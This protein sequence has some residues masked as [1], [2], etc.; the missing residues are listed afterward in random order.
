M[1]GL[2]ERSRIHGVRCRAS[3]ATAL[4]T[5]LALALSGCTAPKVEVQPDKVV[6]A[7][8]PEGADASVVFP[9]HHHITATVEA[10]E[11]TPEMTAA[12]PTPAGRISNVADFTISE[13]EF[14]DAGAQISF[15]RKTPPPSGVFSLIAHWNEEKKTWEPLKTE[16]SEDRLTLTATVQ[17]FS[18]YSIMDLGQ[19]LLDM[20]FYG[21]GLDSVDKVINGTAQWLGAQ[22]AHPTC[23]AVPK[24]AWAEVIGQSSITNVITSCAS[25]SSEYPERL[26]VKVTVNRSYAGYLTTRGAPIRSNQGG[27]GPGTGV[28][29]D[30][31][32]SDQEVVDNIG[33]KD[34]VDWKAIGAMMVSSG[35]MDLNDKAED[36]DLYPVM[37]FSTYEFEFTEQDV[38]A[39]WSGIEGDGK[40]LITFNTSWELALTGLLTGMVDA[41]VVIDDNKKDATKKKLTFLTLFLQLN[42]C[43]KTT[44]VTLT[45]GR[46]IP[47]GDNLMSLINCISTVESKLY[48]ELWEKTGILKQGEYRVAKNGKTYHE[49][50]AKPINKAIGKVFA[51]VA[52]AGIGATIG[53]AI[54][55]S[56]S[57][58]PADRSIYFNSGATSTKAFAAG[59]WSWYTTSD[60]KYQFLYPDGW[61]VVPG[62]DEPAASGHNLAVVNEDGQIVS[63][64]LSGLTMPQGQG[65][66]MAERL[67]L[68]YRGVYG[69]KERSDRTEN[70]FSFQATS[71]EQKWYAHLGVSSFLKTDED[72]TWPRG[73]DISGHDPALIGG[74]FGRSIG[75]DETLAGVGADVLADSRLLEYMKSQ[76]YHQV[77]AMLASLRDAS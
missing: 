8:L 67:E 14:P 46:F 34:F 47:S 74:S 73:F 27:L 30:R 52:G 21:G 60:K 23:S 1:N 25:G 55:D 68:D 40:K 19:D 38:M 69:L 56:Y 35:L 7:S 9:G 29:L 58:D 18:S 48:A 70:G 64:F 66:M 4:L 36:S 26:S 53:T 32:A 45:D 15:V 20:A 37:P 61:T 41:A 65:P 24:P 6:T 44:N 51:A 72:H 50:Y 33:D 31:D 71:Y 39:D 16:Q 22:T 10:R 62:K 11:V 57:L 54:N 28:E 3:A 17:H 43:I 76:E 77:R 42:D 49:M 12:L 13:G 59:P 5:V 75:P 63:T 2:L